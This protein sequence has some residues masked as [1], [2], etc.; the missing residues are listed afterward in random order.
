MSAR[1]EAIKDASS[2]RIYFEPQEGRPSSTP[3]V[4]IKDKYGSTITASSTSYVTQVSV[5][6]TVA[7]QNSVGDKSLV[8]ASVS[9]IEFRKSYLITNSKLQREWVRVRSVDSSNATVEFDEALEFVHDT[10]A[11]FQ[12]TTFYRTLQTAEVDDLVEGYRARAS[13]TVNSMTYVQEIPFDVVLTP[14]VNPLTVEFLK[15][16]RKNIMGREHASTRGTDY[17]DLREAAWDKVLK[18]IRAHDAGWRPALLKSPE[19]VE[20]WAL[21]EFDLLLHKS[22]V[23]QMKNVDPIQAAESLKD[24]I[25]TAKTNSLGNLQYM[26]LSDDDSLGTDEERPKRPDFVR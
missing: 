10:S 26:D 6:T 14:L 16:R 7:T 12:S 4:E 17:L 13:Y 20:E 24:E 15:V 23:Q 9:G 8:L 19:D 3:S 2:Q 1:I 21:A 22:G 25:K 11:T 5:N 18:G